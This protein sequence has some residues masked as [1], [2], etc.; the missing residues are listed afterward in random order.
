M[1]NQ[2]ITKYS[3]RIPTSNCCLSRCLNL[4]AQVECLPQKGTTCCACPCLCACPCRASQ[5]QLVNVCRHLISISITKSMPTLPAHFTVPFFLRLLL[6]LLLL[7]LL[8][9]CCFCIMLPPCSTHTRTHTMRLCTGLF[10][11]RFPPAV[12]VF[13]VVHFFDIVS[14]LFGSVAMR[15]CAKNNNNNNSS[16]SATPRATRQLS[17]MVFVGR[18]CHK[19]LLVRGSEARLERARGKQRGREKK[20]GNRRS[21]QKEWSYDFVVFPFYNFAGS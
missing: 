17:L 9:Y 4:C 18:W 15:G 2:K 13:V 12:V 6:L 3:K 14:L 7:L 19:F 11:P 20:G 10:E 8:F 5:R 1:P 21:R 16:N